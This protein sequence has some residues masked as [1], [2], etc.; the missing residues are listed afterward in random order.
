M[1]K[2]RRSRSTSPRSRVEKKGLLA[3]TVE[4]CRSLCR[5]PPPVRPAAPAGCFPVLVGPERER[6][7]VRADRANHPLFRALL[8]E[9][10]AEYGFPRPAAAEPLVLPCGADEFRR[11]MSEVEQ[12]DEEDDTTRVAAVT[13][14][15]PLSPAWRLFSKGGGRGGYLKMNPT[16]TGAS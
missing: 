10:E 4:R 13:G 14:S 1:E 8:D 9:A 3:K 12:A 7:V 11:V 16:H 6:F 2:L 5:R 15:A